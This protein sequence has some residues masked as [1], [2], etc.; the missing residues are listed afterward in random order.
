MLEQQ[1]SPPETAS[2]AEVR[3]RV[4]EL[5]KVYKDGTGFR[6]FVEE[7]WYN[8]DLTSKHRSFLGLF[9]FV[10]SIAMIGF[11]VIGV[12]VARIEADGPAILAS[13]KCGLWV[14][15]RQRGGDEAATR[16]GINDLAKETRAGSYAQNC[17]GTPDPFDAIQCN[18][19]Y[20]NKLSFST[21]QYTTDCPFQTEICGQNQTVTFITDTVDASELGINSQHS[22]KFRRRTSCTPL[23]MDYP[24]IQ[25]K[26]INGTTTYYYYYGE[27]PL[28]NPPVNYTYITTGD[29]FDRLAP[30]YDLL[31]VDNASSYSI[32][33]NKMA[34]HTPRVRQPRSKA[35]GS[36][37]PS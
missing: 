16:A 37:D 9:I 6:E 18:F 13:E 30:A 26:T 12:Y 7:L 11:I 27:K 8:N 20:R 28:H 15:D 10:L 35:I 25:N 24:F 36:Q 17:Y 14:F 19:L 4:N 23:S 32:Y 2:G 1:A 29:P 5:S 3:K 34:V 22:P 21:A 31:Y 33:A